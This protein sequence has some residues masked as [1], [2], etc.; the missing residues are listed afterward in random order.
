MTNAELA[1]LLGGEVRFDG[2]VNASGRITAN[3]RTGDDLY[4]FWVGTSTYRDASPRE[5]LLRLAAH[6]RS[7]AA[8]AEGLIAK[9]PEPVQLEWRPYDDGE[10]ETRLFVKR[11]N[12]YGM[13]VGFVRATLRGFDCAVRP[14][15]DEYRREPLGFFADL[16]VAQETVEKAVR[17]RLA[18]EAKR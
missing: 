17:E 4:E 9:L 6:H 8:E 11:G 10:E 7:V 16:G 12:T 1:K 15:G 13:P 3:Y 18:S 2:L 5:A 14:V